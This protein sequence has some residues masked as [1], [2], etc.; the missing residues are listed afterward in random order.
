MIPRPRHPL[1][2]LVALVV[3]TLL[4]YTVAGK[5]RASI[6]VRSTKANLTLVNMPQD[7]VLAGGVPD[8]VILRLRG[9]LSTIAGSY[10]VLEVL[11][12]LSEARP[13]RNSYPIDVSDMRLPQNVEVLAVEPA[14]IEIELERLQ[15][16][17]LVVEPVVSGRPAP[18]FQVTRVVADPA[19]LTVQ[20][21]ESRILK[22]KNIATTPVMVEGVRGPIE[23]SVEVIL[24]DP[25]IRLLTVGSVTVQ[26]EITP[27]LLPD[28]TTES[29][30][31]S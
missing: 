28:P 25:S 2:F 24:Q 21:P 31:S 5:R 19:R 12:D 29:D 26:I 22:M 13:G 10:R 30:E 6:S 27:M 20:G 17:M 14:E 1:Y 8:T 7:L 23:A 3:A 18:G 4:W 16:R 9:P 11:L 15:I